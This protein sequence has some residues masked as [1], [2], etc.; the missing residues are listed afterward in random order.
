MITKLFQHELEHKVNIIGEVSESYDLR[1]IFLTLGFD[2]TE[3]DSTESYFLIHSLFSEQK[4]TLCYRLWVP[5]RGVA[6]QLAP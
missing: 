2:C 4:T 6:H 1:Q 3:K 5:F